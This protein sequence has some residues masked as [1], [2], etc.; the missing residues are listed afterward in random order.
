MSLALSA[1]W[2]SRFAGLIWFDFNAESLR[3]SGSAGL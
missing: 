1:L 3:N 2:R